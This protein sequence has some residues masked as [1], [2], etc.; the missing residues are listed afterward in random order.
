[1]ARAEDDLWWYRGMRRISDRLIDEAFPGRTDLRILDAGCGTGRNLQHFRRRGTVTGLDVAPPALALARQ[2]DQDR[3]V[4]GSV[5]A[6]PFPRDAFDL[7][8]SFDVIYHLAVRSEDTA[9]QE[10]ARVLRPG[11]ALLL[12]V[13]AHDWL[14]SQH[15]R[16]VHTRRRFSRGD[17]RDLVQRA[18]LRPVRVSYANAALFPAAA[19]ARLAERVAKPAATAEPL[20]HPPAR[21]VNA[22][23]ATILSLEAA[24]VVRPGLPFGLSVVC[25][26][27][28]PA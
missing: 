18:G 3:L 24:L 26:A 20:E 10:F 23:L 19:A 13:P 5:D 4:R 15:D 12:R 11:G 17:V 28:K 2:R 6:L 22:A 8:T 27:R 14:R 1:M 9:L 7:V 16:A 25:L 21:P